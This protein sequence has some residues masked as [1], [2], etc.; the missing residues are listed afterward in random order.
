MHDTMDHRPDLTIS[1]RGDANPGALFGLLLGMLLGALTMFLFDPRLGRS[2]R[3]RLEQ[4][5]AALGRDARR[6]AEGT[7][8]DMANRASGFAAEHDLPTPDE[9]GLGQ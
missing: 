5:A 4:Q 2:R 7:G 8:E 9:P 1:D 6:A 3:I